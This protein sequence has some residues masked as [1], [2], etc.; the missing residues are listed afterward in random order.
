MGDKGVWKGNKEEHS[1]S[2]SKDA[3]E[4]FVRV[5]NWRT[6]HEVKVSF[7][8][9]AMERTWKFNI[10]TD[11]NQRKSLLDKGLSKRS[12]S[13]VG[14]G[15]PLSVFSFILIIH[16]SFGSRKLPFLTKSRPHLNRD[17]VPA[18]VEMWKLRTTTHPRRNRPVSSIS[19]YCRL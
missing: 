1:D 12:C 19:V 10:I 14:T 3:A 13:N 6:C 17:H 11:I 4:S 2:N 18:A 7:P 5:Y 8:Q 9:T 15:N 16:L